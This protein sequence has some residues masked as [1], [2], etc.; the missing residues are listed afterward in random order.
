MGLAAGD[1]GHHVQYC[2]Y[3][4]QGV[5]VSGV[6]CRKFISIAKSRREYIGDA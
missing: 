4:Y 3:L 2:E 5:A 6:D 1:W